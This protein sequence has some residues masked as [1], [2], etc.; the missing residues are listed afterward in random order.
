LDRVKS[1]VLELDA[2]GTIGVGFGGGEP[3]LYPRFAELCVYT[4]R[5]TQLA[6]TFTT[7]GH[8]LGNDLLQRLEG[9]VHFVRISMD[10]VGDTYQRLRRRSFR[11]L[12]ERLEALRQISR[13]GINYVV[14][15]DTIPDL[16]TAVR[17]ADECGAAEFLL[18]PER[19]AHGRPGITYMAARKLREWVTAYRG[20]VP[21]RTSDAGAHGLPV[22]DPFS[23]DAPLDRYA[24]IDAAGL[25]KATSFD[26]AGIPI[27]DNFISALSELRNLHAVNP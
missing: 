26:R 17:L 11:L 12:L 23:S 21:L 19:P 9:Y 20:N 18:L 24:H 2:N 1:W 10:G 16:D 13:F 7:H 27:L 3:T 4:T 8:H 5:Q 6:V 25:L 14:N 15:D 22:C